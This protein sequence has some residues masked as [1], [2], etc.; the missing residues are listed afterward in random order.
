M[1]PRVLLDLVGGATTPLEFHHKYVA[2]DQ[3][4][5]KNNRWD[6]TDQSLVV[7]QIK[8]R[9]EQLPDLILNDEEKA[10]RC[11]ILWFWYHHAI[12]CAIWKKRDLRQARIFVQRAL[13]YQGDKHPNQIT[14]L[15]DLLLNDRFDKAKAWANAIVDPVEHQTAVNVLD[16]W[17]MSA[18]S[19]ELE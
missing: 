3:K 12:G 11:E 8:V 16:W 10:W 6:Y 9:L 1:Y 17:T 14:K 7:N 18:L 19:P 15:F 5:M 4:L 2:L 13:F